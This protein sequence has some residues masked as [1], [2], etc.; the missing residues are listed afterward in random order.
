MAWDSTIY[1]N[2][3]LGN[4]GQRIGIGQ[5]VQ[6]GLAFDADKMQGAF[7]RGLKGAAMHLPGGPQA[8]AASGAFSQPPEQSAQGEQDLWRQYAMMQMMKRGQG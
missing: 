7:A 1:K 3:P 6:G 4:I 2:N 5:N 8:V